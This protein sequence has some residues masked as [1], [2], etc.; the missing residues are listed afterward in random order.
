MP[1]FVVPSNSIGAN[2]SSSSRSTARWA[3]EPN[4]QVSRCP[5]CEILTFVRKKQRRLTE[6]EQSGKGE[7]ALDLPDGHQYTFMA[8]IVRTTS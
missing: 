3:G 6:A 7:K 8:W 2:V 1:T 4:P 5:P